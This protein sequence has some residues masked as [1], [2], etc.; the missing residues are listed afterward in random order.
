MI[1]APKTKTNPN[2]GNT[3]YR[4]GKSKR[5]APHLSR[6]PVIDNAREA[7]FICLALS[8]SRLGSQ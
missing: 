3:G 8:S 2:A 7:D 4:R 5:T 1:I 6:V